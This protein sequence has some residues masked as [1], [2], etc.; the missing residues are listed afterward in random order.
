MPDG[1]I[2]PRWGRA[3]RVAIATV[4]DGSIAAWQEFEVGW[5]TA[6]GSGPEGQHHARIARFL[7]E[8]GVQTIVADHM[9]DGMRQKVGRM[10][11]AVRLGAAGTARDAVA[12]KPR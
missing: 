7:Q 6:H 2:D 1:S 8:H 11:I 4:N 10:G 5:D 3:Q 9:G 12:Y